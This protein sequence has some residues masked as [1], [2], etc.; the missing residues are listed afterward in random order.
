MITK[1]K[2]TKLIRI[3]VKGILDDIDTQ[4]D[5]EELVEDHFFPAEMH[6]EIPFINLEEDDYILTEVEIN[7][8]QKMIEEIWNEEVER[9]KQLIGD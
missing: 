7:Q 8:A 4:R 5:V 1:E 3:I 6:K 9:I 2:L